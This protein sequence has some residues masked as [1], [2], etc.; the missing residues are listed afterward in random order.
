ML[1]NPYITGR[2]YAFVQDR[3]VA[4]TR[5]ISIPLEYIALAVVALG[6]LSVQRGNV[7]LERQLQTDLTTT[8]AMSR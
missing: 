2:R 8:Y 6:C 3:R 7:A 5:A 4:R 1:S